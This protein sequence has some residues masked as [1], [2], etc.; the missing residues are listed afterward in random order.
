MVNRMEK[1]GISNGII[2]DHTM[3]FKARGMLI[4]ALANEGNKFEFESMF[5]GKTKI[6]SGLKELESSGCL[7]RIIYR[8][9]KSKQIHSG[10]MIFSDQPYSFDMSRCIK[11]A[12][13]NDLEIFNSPC[14]KLSKRRVMVQVGDKL[15]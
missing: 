8:E 10:D 15:L 1:T 11:Y 6:N 5:E 12:E 2:C 14:K 9:K 3:S 7:K 13:E 4:L